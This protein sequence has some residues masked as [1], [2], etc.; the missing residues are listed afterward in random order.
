VVYIGDI[1]VE[2]PSPFDVFLDDSARV[3]DD[4]KY[5]I[6]THYMTPEEIKEK[7]KL[8]V[9]A[10]SVAS[11]PDALLP[12]GGNNAQEPTTKAVQ[13]GYFLPQAS[14]PNGRYVTWIDE[15]IVE[16]ESWPYPVDVLPLIKF[17]GMRVPGQVYDGSVVEQAVPI[18]K[19]LNKTL[20]QIIEYKN[21]TVK[22]RVWAPTGSLS[23][24]RM[25]SEPGAIYEFNPV[26]DHKPEIEQL[27]SLPP[28]IFDHLQEIRR[29]LREIFGIA[30][31]TEGTPPPNVEAGIAIDLLQEM[32]TDR[33]AP[34]ILL[35]ERA[36]VR[37]GDIMLNFAQEYYKEPRLLKISG[38][39]TANKVTKFNQADLKGGVTIHVETG[40][41]LPRT[42]AGRQARIMDY[43]DKGVIRVDQAYKYLDI[44]DLAGLGAMFQA[45]EDQAYREHDKLLAGEP[46][47]IVEMNAAIQQIE[48]GQAVDETGEVLEDPQAI[49]A[50]VREASLQP[51]PFENLAT[52]LDVH[53]L[54]MKSSE[55]EALPDETKAG[56]LDHYRLTQQAQGEMPAAMEFKPVTPTLQIKATAGPTA[57]STI[58]SKAGVPVTPEDMSEPPLETWVSDKI[59][60]P[61]QD[62]AGNDPLTESDLQLKE[63]EYQAKLL[64]AELRTGRVDL[65]L[66]QKQERHPHQA[67]QDKQKARKAKADA[68]L[69]EKK[70]KQSDFRPKPKAK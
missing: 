2:V 54:F 26:G 17:P 62:E 11:A 18:Q 35:I 39:G 9:K 43:V 12:Y 6:C 1:K 40:S 66:S 64:D 16:D 44:A 33:L 47:N 15:K 21:L 60:E 31:V 58:L 48:S 27:P 46:V 41:A 23:G 19:D 7:F 10:D 36:L 4:C 37:A 50:Y 68:D 32:A 55:F 63:A 25:T 22:P 42:R 8:D 3:F 49:E 38:S 57:V 67:E 5:M 29:D 51:H 30:D 24:V 70:A 61:D 20:S 65:D 56:F 13:V 34:T 45:D 28:Y 59:D 69:A 14:L 52:H 53:S